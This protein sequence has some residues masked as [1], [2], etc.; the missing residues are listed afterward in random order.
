MNQIHQF[1]L[2]FRDVH[3]F[4]LKCKLI[5][6]STVTS[7]VYTCKCSFIMHVEC[8]EEGNKQ[9]PPLKSCNHPSSCETSWKYSEPYIM[10]NLFC[11]ISIK[12][13]ETINI[14][15]VLTHFQIELFLCFKNYRRYKAFGSNLDNFGKIWK[16][17]N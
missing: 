17:Q 14:P 16:I 13:L 6:S 1:I 12:I 7:K 3:T 15:W 4:K 10:R 5:F 11:Q 8:S 2:C 9:P